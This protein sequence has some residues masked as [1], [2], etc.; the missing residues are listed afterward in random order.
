MITVKQKNNIILTVRRRLDSIEKTFGLKSGAYQDYKSKIE[1][2]F[3]ANAVKVDNS[4]KIN[5]ITKNVNIGNVAMNKV[6]LMSHTKTA[7][8]IVNSYRKAYE[9]ETGKKAKYSQLK[10]F[11]KKFEN[12]RG[13]L[14]NVLTRFYEKMG[15]QLPTDLNFLHNSKN[16]YSEIDL[17]VK[18]L[19]KLMQGES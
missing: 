3:G 12:V 17:A 7:Q 15:T 19:T 18:R 10:E 2:A 14:T 16:S 8:Q 5:I 4:G 9:K 13:E 6:W 1:T 11:A